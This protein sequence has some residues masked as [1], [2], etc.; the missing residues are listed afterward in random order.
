MICTWYFSINITRDDFKIVSNFTRLTA[1]EIMY[2]NFER[3]L[4]V[5]MPN[6][7]T[8]HAITFSNCWNS[9]QSQELY[10]P[11]PS[12]SSYSLSCCLFTL[13]QGKSC[14]LPISFFTCG[15]DYI[16][17]YPRGRY[18]SCW[19]MIGNYKTRGRKSGLKGLSTVSWQ[20]NYILFY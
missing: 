4:V 16:P 18:R 7:T 3:S 11:F 5:F 13:A 10:W 6:I 8:N 14:L 2:N 15:V 1:R 20:N 9:H 17:M 19:Q 12:L